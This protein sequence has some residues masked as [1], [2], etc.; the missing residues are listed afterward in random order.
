M[1]KVVFVIC[2]KAQRKGVEVEMMDR[3]GARQTFKQETGVN[4]NHNRPANNVC[5][6]INCDHKVFLTLTNY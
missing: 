4:H 6:F 3:L 5:L 1:L 2:N